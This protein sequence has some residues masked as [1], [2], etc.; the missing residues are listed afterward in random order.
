VRLKYGG[1]EIFNRTKIRQDYVLSR[2]GMNPVPEYFDIVPD[3]FDN[4]LDVLPVGG[5]KLEVHCEFAD[6]PGGAATAGTGNVKIITQWE[7]RRQ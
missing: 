3:M 7:G 5:R 1:K 4:P 2:H 6:A